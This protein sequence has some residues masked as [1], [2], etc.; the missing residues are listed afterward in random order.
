[1]LMA[2]DFLEKPIP[3][4]DQVRGPAF[5]GRAPER[6]AALDVTTIYKICQRTAWQEAQSAGLYRGSAVDHHDGFIHFSTAAQVGETAARHFA[7]QTDLMLV[8]VDG[9]AL[10]SA[11]KWEPSRGGALFPHLY[12]ALPVA[13]VRWA[14][15]LPDE[16]GGRREIAELDP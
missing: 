4:S 9:S 11:L 3:P 8:A 5:P 1:M 13:G 2:H 10:G 7:G 14:R 16:I 6:W 15:P 12:G